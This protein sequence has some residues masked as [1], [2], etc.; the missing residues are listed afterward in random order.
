MKAKIDNIKGIFKARDTTVPQLIENLEQI[1]EKVERLTLILRNPEFVSI[2]LVSIPTE[3]GF[4]ECARTISFLERMGIPIE[5]IIVNNIM[6]NFGEEEWTA[7]EQHP[8]ID[9]VKRHYDSQQPH[10]AAFKALCG[11]ENISLV[12]MSLL[13]FEPRA[14]RLIDYAKILYRSPSKGGFN[15][16]PKPIFDG[17]AE[18]DI[19]RMSIPYIG[20]A[21]WA[22]LSAD[23]VEVGYRFN[24]FNFG[25]DWDGFYRIPAN[26]LDPSS[27]YTKRKTGM[28][29]ITFSKKED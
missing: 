4:Q 10:L 25:D 1:C 26:F 21:K 16:M 24:T 13:P 12:G 8:S 3:S 6:P 19:V 5:H 18:S 23:A 20:E 29:S 2:N 9:L 17:D 27:K 14:E 11:K 7:A 22:N 28:H 15:W